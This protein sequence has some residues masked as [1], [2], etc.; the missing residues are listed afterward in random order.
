MNEITREEFMM[1]KNIWDPTKLDDVDEA[2]DLM[3]SQLPPI[4]LDAIDSFY[5][6]E[7]DICATKSDLK[8]DSKVDPAIVDSEVGPAV[9][10]NNERYHPKPTGKEYRSKEEKES[11]EM[12]QRQ[13]D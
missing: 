8:V 13:E 12:D 7:G 4:P 11:R 10:E 9:V 6:D 3:L 5:N 1:S 2:S